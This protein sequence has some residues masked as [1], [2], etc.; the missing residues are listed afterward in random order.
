IFYTIYALLATIG[1]ISNSILLYTTI[2]TSSLRSPC[3][4]LIGACALFD[5]LHQL[6]IFP[7]ATVIYRGATMHSWTCSVIM[8]IPEMGCAAGSFAV[9][10]IGLDRLLS[11]IAP[12]RYQ[13]SN[14]RAYLTV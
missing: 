10:S 8:F 12:N 7:V 4:I 3:N 13:Q 11:V 5:V 6:G 2:R 9:L 1:V 14:K